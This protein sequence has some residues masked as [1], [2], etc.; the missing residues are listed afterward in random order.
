MY[1]TVQDFVIGKMEEVSY[2]HQVFIL[3]N[4]PKIQIHIYKSLFFLLEL[5]SAQ[6]VPQQMF[7][8][9]SSTTERSWEG[10]VVK[11]FILFIN[12]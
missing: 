7:P 1:T 10:D 5:N 2:A 6:F 12:I 3:F 11:Y 8:E 9:N 4:P